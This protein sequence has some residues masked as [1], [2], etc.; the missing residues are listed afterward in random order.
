MFCDFSLSLSLIRGH[1]RRGRVVGA[2][3]ATSVA[4]GDLPAKGGASQRRRRRRPFQRLCLPF[5]LAC[6]SPHDVEL[7]P[8]LRRH[9]QDW[10][11]KWRAGRRRWRRRRRPDHGRGA[12]QRW[13]N[14]SSAAGGGAAAAAFAGD[15][16][17]QE[18]SGEEG[19]AGRVQSPEDQHRQVPLRRQ[20]PPLSGGRPLS[21]PH[22]PPRPQP[23][24]PPRFSRL[25]HELPGRK[26]PPPPSMYLSILS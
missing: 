17:Q 2:A 3:A 9:V 26:L 24:R 1:G 21:L 20:P 13:D 14:S 4:D 12:Q 16:Q 10:G 7:R 6:L 11:E 18:H 22:H 23:H 15:E 5:R 25:P 8:S 19:G